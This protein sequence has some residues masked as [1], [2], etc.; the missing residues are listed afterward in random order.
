MQI[1]RYWITPEAMS[2]TRSSREACNSW[3]SDCSNTLHGARSGLQDAAFSIFKIVD[4]LKVC[5][6]IV[7]EHA[8]TLIF[9]MNKYIL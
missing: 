2:R 6:C 4:Q 3:A 5:L 7:L 8:I 1:T 9:A